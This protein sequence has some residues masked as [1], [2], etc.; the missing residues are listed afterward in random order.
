MKEPYEK[1]RD[2]FYKEVN[3]FW[4]GQG[5]K[6]PRLLSEPLYI[7]PEKWGPDPDGENVDDAQHRY[8]EDIRREVERRWALLCL[9]YGMDRIMPRS[10]AGWKKLCEELVSRH[11]PGFVITNTPPK[12]KK[13]PG[14]PS[15]RGPAFD[16]ELVAAVDKARER[17]AK[18]ENTTPDK[19]S[20]P[21]AIKSLDR[22]FLEKWPKLLDQWKT[23]RGKNSLKTR[24][25]EAKQI[26]NAWRNPQPTLLERLGKQYRNS[27]MD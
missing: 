16:A 26:W 15:T 11:V 2:Q 3:D 21:K 18:D 20:V 10:M 19:V 12:S 27:E 14:A 17:V 8:R 5:G 22:K 23:A 1:A 9:M 4:N 7:D 13:G 24:Y 25:H 6:Y